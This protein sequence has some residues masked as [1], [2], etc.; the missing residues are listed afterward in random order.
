M[1]EKGAMVDERWERRDAAL[2]EL[3]VKVR[4]S[5]MRIIKLSSTLEHQQGFP[6]LCMHP[7]GSRR[8]IARSFRSFHLSACRG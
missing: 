1:V 7:I 5:I 8:C 2:K 3:E 4:G 6:E